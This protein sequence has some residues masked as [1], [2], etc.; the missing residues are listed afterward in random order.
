MTAWDN[1]RDNDISHNRKVM[2]TLFRLR[3][4]PLL[5]HTSMIYLLP[6]IGSTGTGTDIAGTGTDIAGT[7]TDIAGAG[8]VV[9]RLVPSP[10]I[11]GHML[12]V[13]LYLHRHPWS[14][15]S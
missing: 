15:S 6:S 12:M 4:D 14:T 7:G 8:T 2:R 11:Y 10:W 13:P 1:E 9:L 5:F 3:L